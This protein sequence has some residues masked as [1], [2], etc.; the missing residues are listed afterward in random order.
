MDL[1]NTFHKKDIIS[2]V[3]TELL[4]YCNKNNYETKY[5][6]S[7]I[8]VFVILSGVSSSLVPWEMLAAA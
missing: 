2:K 3:G 6:L 8:C 4:H 7:F 5:E 1:N